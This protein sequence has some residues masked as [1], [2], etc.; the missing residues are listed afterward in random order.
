MLASARTPRNPRPRAC[1]T[2]YSGL[3]RVS[4]TNLRR[5]DLG[6]PSRRRYFCARAKVGQYPPIAVSSVTTACRTAP[7]NFE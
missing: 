7:T 5:R 3:H 2:R 4:K 6:G 1:L